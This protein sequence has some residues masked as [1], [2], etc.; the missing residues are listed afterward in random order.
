MTA[1][2][3]VVVVALAVALVQVAG[4]AVWAIVGRGRRPD[5]RRMHR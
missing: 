5:D 3:V 4:V 2:L 1:T